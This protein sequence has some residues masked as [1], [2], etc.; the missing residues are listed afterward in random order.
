MAVPQKVLTNADLEQMVDTSDAWIVERTGIRERRVASDEESTSTFAIQASHEALR[1]AKLSPEDVDLVLCATCSGD[2][3]WPATACIVQGE[4]GLK[5]AAAFDLSAA[6]AGFCYGLRVAASLIESGACEH[7][8]LVAADTLTRY[9]DWSDRSTCI[10]FGDGAGAVVLG[11]VD[12]PYGVLASS[13]GADGERVTSLYVPAG[14]TRLP[15][16]C[17]ALEARLDKMVMHGGEVFKFAVRIMQE[18]CLTALRNAQ[19]TPEQV[20]LFIPHQANIRIIRSAAE[21]MRLEEDRVFVNVDRYG[22]TSAASI[23]IALYE[24][25]EQGRV[26]DGDV[27]VFVG[28]GA[29]LTWSANVVRWGPTR[30][31]ARGEQVP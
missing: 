28:F 13:W 17:Q 21:K 24:A 19:I 5:N 12:E 8:L 30:Q 4:L 27:L 25:V 1:D 20:D 10:L 6:C 31:A 7:V 15:I 23:P 29:G 14:G 9:V 16:T 3:P 26:H 18:A 11:P 2:Y 22:N